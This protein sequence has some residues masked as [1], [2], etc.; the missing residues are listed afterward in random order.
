MKKTAL[1]STL[2]LAAA[3][4]SAPAVAQSF[5][6]EVLERP[7]PAARQL[8]PSAATSTDRAEVVSATPVI[9]Q[10]LVSGRSCVDQPVVVQRQPSGAGALLGAVAGAAVGNA[11]GGGSGRAAATAIGL[12]GGAALGNQIEAGGPDAG[13]SR[14]ERRCNTQSVYE[15]RVIG[16]DVVYDYNGRSFTTRMRNDPGE[17]VQVQVRATPLDD[18]APAVEAPLRKRRGQPVPLVQ[19]LPSDGVTYA[20][21]PVYETYSPYPPA[22]YGPYYAPSPYYA[23][24][25]AP[26]VVPFGT[27]L[28]L[29]ALI[30]FGFDRGYGGHRGHRGWHGG[31]R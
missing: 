11:V 1:V 9:R 28:A 14:V 30:G 24:Y 4:L 19:G 16:Y 25:Y 20:A 15:D 23:P 12:I 13:A 5:A 10:V 22:Y 6:R 8:A 3:A 26:S 27:G 17:F 7:I 29:G 18:P 31:R 2:A 21:E